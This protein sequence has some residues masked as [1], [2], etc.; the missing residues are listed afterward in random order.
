MKKRF[1][2]IFRS[3]VPLLTFALFSNNVYAQKTFT[4]DG[5]DG[6]STV[7]WSLDQDWTPYGIP[8]TGDDVT[9]DNTV[10]GITYQGLNTDFTLPGI[11]FNSSTMQ[12]LS[13]NTF[14][15]PFPET[16]SLN[17]A[18]GPAELELGT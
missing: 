16:L 13:A 6:T 14:S 10:S 15:T 3:I 1:R 18:G 7:D 8:G 9:V 5:T 12:G 11:L 2:W 17:G 4:G